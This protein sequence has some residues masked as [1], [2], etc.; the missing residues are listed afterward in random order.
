ARGRKA[1]ERPGDRQRPR[2]PH[3]HQARG[4]H[5][6]ARGSDC[7][8]RSDHRLGAACGADIRLHG[9]AAHSFE[10]TGRPTRRRT[11]AASKSGA[12]VAGVVTGAVVGVLG[13]ALSAEWLAL[14]GLLVAVTA[15]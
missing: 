3:P 7:A 2:P 9:S 14:I 8:S 10:M 12:L 4:G 5:P 13:L 11:T 1:A 15:A 6:H